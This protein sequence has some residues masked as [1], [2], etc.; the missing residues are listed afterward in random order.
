MRSAYKMHRDKDRVET[1]NMANQWL[2]QTETHPMGKNQS[3]TVLMI[4]CYAYRQ[5]PRLTV[6]W[7]A[8]PRS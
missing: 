3:L 8:L 1:E 7:G 6:L 5:E 2:A 4:L